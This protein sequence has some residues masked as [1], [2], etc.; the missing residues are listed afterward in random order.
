MQSKILGV[1]ATPLFAITLLGQQT[2]RP[3]VRGVDYAVSTRTPEATQVG[4]RILRA[5]GNAFDAAVASQAALA[6]TD[7]S[8]NGVGSDA[9][10]LLYDAKSKQVI[11]L[12]A[13]GPAPRLATIEWYRKNN[14]GK[15][16][17]SDGLLSGTVPGVV[18]AWY[19]ILDRWG[20]MSFE[21]TLEPAI[22]L[23]ERGF[24]LGE[25]LA[26]A[27]RGGGEKRYL[28]VNDEGVRLEREAAG[29]GNRKLAKYP[30]SARIYFPDGRL[31]RVGQMFRNPDLARTLKKLVE[32]EKENASKGRG[33]ALKAARDRFYKGDIARTF[34]R[35]SE[36]NGG[37]FRYDDF[38][39]Y[40]SKIETPV[41]LNYRGY[42]VYKNPSST[43]GPAEIFT[44]NILRGYDLKAMRHNSADYIHYGV[45]AVKLAFADRELYL[46]DMDFIKIPFDTLLSEPYG[47]ARRKLVDPERAS[48][49]FR[50]GKIDGY[51][52]IEFQIPLFGNADHEGDTSYLAV[53]D[54]DRNAV[55]FTPSLHSGFGTGVVMGDTGIIFNCRG[56]YYWLD[57][58]HPGAL[59]P[60]KRPRSTLTPTLVMKDGK[61]FMIVGSPGGD[62]QCMRIMQTFLNV[63][64]FGMN[65][66]QA[67]EAPRWST[68]S[69]PSSVFP[70]TM[71]PAAMAVE[72][73]VP[74]SVIRELERRGHRVTV[75]GPWSM[76]ATSAIVIDPETGALSAGADPRGDNYALAW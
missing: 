67:I 29:A 63:A 37:L 60:G 41:S 50:P 45:E 32:T 71:Y 13:E 58:K 18:D 73:R 5:G 34:A 61:P 47:A 21:Q 20:T 23:A 4:E 33:A 55:S 35:F 16:P 31:P 62:D 42:D 76:N 64:D 74:E 25:R 17:D 59:A 22:E 14:D 3:V 2:M 48:R 26:A 15:I 70:H 30:S 9:C 8:N 51:G 11:S 28:S 65:I 69:F 49:E 6:I 56:D 72:N 75:R 7:P 10:I 43:Q 39:T 27:I 36:E 54:R 53:V 66:Q 1:V 38:A 57:P 19:L 40:T 44:L 52:G 24:P 68:T 46:G 12:N